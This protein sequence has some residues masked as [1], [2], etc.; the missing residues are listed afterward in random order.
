M[1]TKK[2]LSILLCV[3]I[4]SCT[5]IF[6]LTAS[7]AA[8]ANTIEELKAKRLEL[9]AL[10]G[11]APE[12]GIVMPP[13]FPEDKPFLLSL[14]YSYKSLVALNEPLR[15]AHLITQNTQYNV[16]TYVGNSVE[17]IETAIANLQ[18]A[19]DALEPPTPL[20]KISWFFSFVCFGIPVLI[21]TSLGMGMSL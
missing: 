13:F 6:S 10:I 5:G 18:A 8:P 1:K 2:L 9:S 12:T 7:A 19:I 14:D 11:K 16:Y 3:A 20:E 21:L 4:L 15:V 17:P